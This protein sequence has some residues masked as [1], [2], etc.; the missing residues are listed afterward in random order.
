ML[1]P[2]EFEKT[3]Y[4]GA[5]EI[6]C[7][8]LL[9]PCALFSFIQDATTLHS[10]R[11]GFSRENFLN[12]Q[13]A[14]WM[15][16]RQK[17]TLLRPLARNDSI[18]VKTSQRGVAGPVWYRDFEFYTDGRPAG[19]CVS[20]WVLVDFHTRS[21]LRPAHLPSGCGGGLTRTPCGGETLEKL[22]LPDGFE[23]SLKASVY[24]SDIDVNFHLNNAL[25]SAFACDAAKLEEA[26]GFYV[27]QMQINYTA[28]AKLGEELCLYRKKVGDV[29][30]VTAQSGDGAPRF[31]TRICLERL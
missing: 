17:Y 10:E 22:A 6:D 8:G 4:V 31:E 12:E 29:F 24:Y 14:V 7:F 26:S 25:A 19:E 23:F 21:I 30:F 27:S 1:N 11:G 5:S 18:T 15:I 2:S 3:Y 16:I 20:A 13:R 9:R 28:E